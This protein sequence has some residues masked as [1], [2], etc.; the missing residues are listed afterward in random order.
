MA[1]IV[2]M[3]TAFEAFTEVGVRQSIIHS[4]RG[5]QSQ[6]LNVA[7]WLQALRGIGLFTIS[8]LLTPWISQ[9]YQKPELLPLLRVSFVVIILNGL[10]SPRIY[11][12]E[13]ELQFTK[14]VLLTQG[15][16]L[17]S[18]LL[19][20][21]LAF[22]VQDVRALVAG[23]LIEGLLRLVL[24]F[25]L[26]PFR[27]RLEIDYDSLGELLRFARGMFGM[28][29][30]TLIT[31]RTDVILL[32]KLVATEKLGVYYIVLSLAQIPF[33]I[34]DRVVSP[35]LLP[36][37]AQKQNDVT[38]VKNAVLKITKATAI[39]G[40]PMVA[41]QIICARA[42]LS[43]AYGP[44]YAVASSTFVFLC[45]YLLARAQGT[46][47]G[48]V[49][50]GLGYPQLHRRFVIL[51]ASILVASIYPMTTFFGLLGA[52]IALTL[53]SF[54][55]LFMQVFWIRKL[56]K[57]QFGMYA[58]QWLGGLLLSLVVIIPVGLMRLFDIGSDV[59]LI[60]TGG[61]TY[62][63]ALLPFSA[64]AFLNYHTKLPQE[65][66]RCG[67]EIKSIYQVEA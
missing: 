52:A 34:F 38:A 13:K 12:L 21:G 18:T 28:A 56:I 26:C 31:F 36:A 33:E 53:S 15:S 11:V 67:T 51:R 65:S 7:W 63:A 35:V 61:V 5:D 14:F 64:W 43:L 66:N 41:I 55:A 4:E 6:Y 2:A 1:T 45:L 48:Q 8:F 54:I 50:M 58:F 40:I 19:T 30:L 17:L 3:S 32:G 23:F 22:Y 49:F 59:L 24:S 47:L 46:I 25:V 9:F 10:I 60:I 39:L 16:G 62:L 44:Q 37:F 42:L 20:V 29:I 27:P 57:L